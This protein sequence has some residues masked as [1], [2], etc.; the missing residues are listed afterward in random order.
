MNQLSRAFTAALIGVSFTTAALAQKGS[1]PLHDRITYL[2]Q[3]T[4]M[5]GDSARSTSTARIELKGLSIGMPAPQALQIILGPMHE[6]SINANTCRTRTASPLDDAYLFGDFMVECEGSDFFG[7]TI[8]H[9]AASFDSGKLR[10]VSMGTF[11]SASADG[12]E[13]PA[14]FRALAN[15]FQVNPPVEKLVRSQRWR[16]YDFSA[17]FRD[18]AGSVL[19]STGRLEV[20][21]WGTLHNAVQLQL[22]GADFDEYMRSRFQK[23]QSYLSQ[24]S[25]Q[26]LAIRSKDL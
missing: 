8:S 23:S 9:F 19:R 5:S 7:D 18:R 4:P 1:I 10:F 11:I 17:S 22:H 2:A 25:A 20:N 12:D 3:S 15:K 14:V 6:Q 13:L 26:V 24:R 16:Q 21:D